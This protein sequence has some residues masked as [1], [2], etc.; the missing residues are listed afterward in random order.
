MRTLLALLLLVSLLTASTSPAANDA[1]PTVPEGWSIELVA[2]APKIHFPTA[3][4]VAPDGAIYVGQDPMDMPGPPTQPIDSVVRIR[5]GKVCLF[6]DKLWAVMGLE[7]VEGTLYVVHAPFLSAFR[8]TNGDGRADERLDLITGLGP[9]QP[10][11]NGINDHVASGVRVGMDGFLY[12]AVGDKGIPRA[13]GKDGR[14]IQLHGG[15]VIRIRPDGTGLEVVSTGERNPLSVALSAHDDIFTYG[16]DDDS[17][18]WPNSLTHHI[19]GGHYG[20]PYQFLAGRSGTA[21]QGQR[22]TPIPRRFLPIVGGQVGGAGAQ[23]VCYTEDGLPA[24]Y[25]G[26]LFLCDWGLQTV[27]RVELEKAGATFRIKS[28]EEFVTSGEFRDFRPFSIAV[29]PVDGSLYL[30]DWAFSGWLATGVESGRLYHLS[31]SGA[32][33]VRIEPRETKDDVAALDHAALSVRLRAQRRLAKSGATAS[34][35]LARRVARPETQYGRLHALWALSE[36]GG[37]PARSALSDCLHD[38]DA[39]LRVQAVRAIGIHPEGWKWPDV[40][41]LLKDKDPAVRREAAIALGRLGQTG[42]GPDLMSA[43][44]DL[45]PFADWSI[46]R[47]IRD[48]KAWNAP[49]LV[50]ALS[51][52]RRREAALSL[53]DEAWSPV[54]VEALAAAAAAVQDAPVRARIVAN[55]AG[56]YRQYPAWSGEWFGTNPLAGQFPQKTQAWDPAAM[57]RIA[58][59]LAAALK[60][61]DAAVR[62]EAIAGVR[63]VGRQSVPSLAASLAAEPNEGNA[64]ALC[65]SLGLLGDAQATVVPLTRVIQDSRRSLPVR[66]AALSALSRLGGRPAF[67]ARLT[68]LYDPQTP[69]ELVAQALPELGR[70]GFLPP[71]DVAEFLEHHDARV[72]AAAVLALAPAKKMPP[73]VRKKIVAMLDDSDHAV[74]QAAIGAVAAQH[75]REAIP[76]L[77]T[78]VKGKEGEAAQLALTTLPD[79]R[80]ISVYADCLN[81]LDARFR[82]PAESALMVIR[83]LAADELQKMARAG[84]LKPW[85]LEAIERI[86]TRSDPVIAWKVIGPFPR[87]TAQLFVGER[88]IDFKQSHAGA[89]GRSVGWVAR[90]AEPTTGR[91]FLDEFK[92]GAGDQ[93][94]FGYDANSS[95]DLCAFGYAEISSDR[96]R[97]ALML[98]GSSGAIT[99]TVNEQAVLDF[100]NS[101]GRPYSPDSNT[102]RI[103]LVKGVNR[104]LVRAR[105][106]IGPWSFSVQISD[107]SS[108]FLANAPK[109]TLDELRSFALAHPGD[110]N[111]G[112]AIF[113][114]A[115]GVGCVKCHSA[116]G[117]GNSQVGPDLTGL[118]LKYD[119][120]EIVRSVLEPSS[121][122]ATGYQPVLIAL[123]NGAVAAGVLR[124]ETQTHLEL[125]DADSRITKISKADL[126]E[127]RISDTSI[128]PAGVVEALT[129]QQFADLIAYLQ[130]LKNPGAAVVGKR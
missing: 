120:A 21:R 79:P 115:K 125:I 10:G 40:S 86:L 31:Y 19:V 25:R 54:V 14:T 3:C 33:R 18:L 35:S 55:L 46:R 11:F 74:R 101:A 67:N 109:R 49:D 127:R 59:A 61:K 28:K 111:K 96:D 93:G 69:T 76:K 78:M 95:P 17:K 42:A 84:D 110:P 72:R 92:A 6:A 103:K 56:L 60:D 5:D 23:A 81:Q 100:T 116:G 99:V 70:T 4:V 66:Q 27:F 126:E 32:D 29:S 75:Q 58:S 98:V 15:G 16:N 68:L 43:L 113:F 62:R 63:R 48:L 122:L 65:E 130:S 83:D 20:Y 85:A 112:R 108:G 91:V 38:A 71:N 119:K 53:T 102:A 47:A 7:W 129:P 57:E 44:G 24:K 97:P 22:T 37:P 105:Q 82:I 106:G 26:N 90:N 124:S 2:D 80:A 121:R 88:S 30:A 73:E 77:L 12:I 45:D 107:S 8:D 41:A 117:M 87:T 52:P 34:P 1:L 36:I 13:A 50:A 118:A 123:K 128:M 39:E 89:E 104:V 64:I 9:K 51:N 114:D 94:G